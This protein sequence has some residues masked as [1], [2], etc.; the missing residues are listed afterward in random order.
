MN[1]TGAQCPVCGK[2]FTETDDI[3]VC[4]VCGTPHHRACYTEKGA[5]AN[6]AHHAEGFSWQPSPDPAAANAQPAV[7]DRLP[8]VTCPHCGAQN[9]ADEPVCTQCGARLY[10]AVPGIGQPPFGAQQPPY[11]A[12]QRTV[13][14][15]PDE[16]L[17]GN[18]VADTAAYVQTGANRYIPKFYAMEKAGKKVQWNWSAFL[19]TPYWF[20]YRKVY[21]AG[22]VFLVLGLL[23]SLFSATPRF[24]EA[25]VS[26]Y[27]A[28]MQ[29]YSGEMS[30]AAYME[31]AQAFFALPETIGFLAGNLVLHI[32]AGLSANWFYKRKVQ[33]DIA[34]LRAHTENPESYR[35]GLLRRGG[36]SALMCIAAIF[37]YYAAQQ[38]L[39]VAFFNLLS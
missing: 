17:G 15:S 10:H 7:P 29:L 3:V 1:Y 23:V 27:N 33:K 26:V 34:A 20:F 16:T 25:Y 2:T 21:A 30:E 38:L 19:F 31:T 39:G 35:L 13:F 36:T 4:P 18:T 8:T 32:A 9:P 24:Q 5:C 11:G 12:P 28:Q 37:I 6:E 14:I 22:A